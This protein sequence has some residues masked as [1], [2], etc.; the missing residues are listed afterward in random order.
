MSGFE[1]LWQLSFFSIFFSTSSF[2]LNIYFSHAFAK[3]VVLKSFRLRKYIL[4]DIISKPLDLYWSH[5]YITIKCVLK[6]WERFF[7]K[8]TNDYALRGKIF[9]NHRVQASSISIHIW[10]EKGLRHRGPCSL[11]MCWPSYKI[12]SYDGMPWPN[13][14]GENPIGYMLMLCGC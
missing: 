4:S 6:A 14:K 2:M 10:K 11:H 1:P 3:E 5:I 12:S 7:L 13:A 9:K 8:D